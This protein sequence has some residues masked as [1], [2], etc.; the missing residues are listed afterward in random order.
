M[1]EINEK[2]ASQVIRKDG[3]KCFLEVQNDYFTVG[4][5]HLFFAKYDVTLQRGSRYTQKVNIYI[6][7]PEFLELCRQILSGV[8]HRD[9]QKLKTDS[10]KLNKPLYTSMG[11][12]SADDLARL[13]NPRKDGMSLSRVAKLCAGDKV[14]Y[15]FIA[16]S[17]PGET[18]AKGLIVPRFGGK[19]EN[20]VFVGLSWESLNHIALISQMHIQ[21]FYNARYMSAVPTQLPPA[22]EPDQSRQENPLTQPNRAPAQASNNPFTSI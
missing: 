18:D 5:V 15:T 11:G 21:A 1:P 4:K 10:D 19:P 6:D 12:T 7:I 13:G 2:N 17:G 16:Q 14:D 22:K 8:T 9:M 3:N 20:S